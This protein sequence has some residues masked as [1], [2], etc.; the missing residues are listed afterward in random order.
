VDDAD[1]LA[2]A[3]PYSA[4]YKNLISGQAPKIADEKAGTTQGVLIR[5]FCGGARSW[6]EMIIDDSSVNPS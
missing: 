1:S 5:R 2:A 4:R 3:D 6:L